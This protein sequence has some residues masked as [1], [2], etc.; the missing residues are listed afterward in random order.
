MARYGIYV[1][2]KRCIGCYSCVVGCKNW[3]Q[4]E[5][6]VGSRIRIV[7]T[8]NG[9]YPDITRW[10]FPIF[11]MQCESPPCVEVC[12][13]EAT[14]KREDGIIVIDEAKCIGC[15]ACVEACPY[16]A[17]YIDEAQQKARKCDFCADRVDEGLIPLC[18]DA[19]PGEALLFGDLDDPNSPITKLIN[20]QDT[21]TLLPNE[22][23]KPNLYY[24][25][26]PEE[27]Y[28]PESV[29]KLTD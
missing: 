10:V 7:D 23:T 15:G 11:C 16:A 25:V 4:I 22:K 3:H 19:C 26:L 29:A 28:N 17:R 21:I 2:V 20:S 1:D 12:P 13:E 9:R 27:L 14:Y 24:G 6:D 18:I 8:I 5:A